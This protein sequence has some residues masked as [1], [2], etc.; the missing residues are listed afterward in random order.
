MSVYGKVTLGA[1]LLPLLLLAYLPDPILAQDGSGA[2]E[3]PVAGS[4]GTIARV[5]ANQKRMEN[6][7]EQYERRQ[8]IELHKGDINPVE[9]KVWRVFP[10]GPAQ[11]KLALKSD[12]TPL[13]PQTYRAE[14]EKLAKYLLWAIQPGAGQREAYAKAEH[15]RRERDDLLVLTQNAFLFT[16]LGTELR[17]DRTLVKYRMEPNPSFKPTTRNSFIF[18]K[19]EG[20]VWI[21]E[22]SGELA[23]IEGR[24]TEDIS[25][26]MF[27][28]KVD[29]GSHFMQERYEFFPGV[30]F[31]S[32]EQFDFDGRKYL[33]PFSIHERTFYS[34]YK[35]V[36]SPG[37][38]VAIIRAE[39]DKLQPN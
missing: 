26:A 4:G 7:L 18:T 6:N 17:G 34:D 23:K 31:P 38:A 16:R 14:L 9:T 28:A 20:N 25:I 27:L 39:L 13:N 35:R 8:R 10:S 15:K 30:W 29:K 3:P 21:D 33:L 12:G 11:T 37:E 24:V 22:Q 36:G 2:A 1:I 5:I 32:Y 19:V